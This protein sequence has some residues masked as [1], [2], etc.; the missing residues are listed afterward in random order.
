MSTEWRS[1]YTVLSLEIDENWYAPEMGTF[2]LH[3]NDLY[4]LYLGLEEI[5]AEE[6][7]RDYLRHIK[8][9][10]EQQLNLTKGLVYISHKAERFNHLR[11]V[12]IQYASPGNQDLAGIGVII[13]HIKDFILRLIELHVS[14]EERRLKNERLEIENLSERIKIAKE[15]GFT[16]KEI[17]NALGWAKKRQ[18]TISDLIEDGKILSVTERRLENHEQIEQGKFGGP[19]T[20]LLKRF[21]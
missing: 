19:F 5:Y 9:Q 18:K 16:D 7:A 4:R 1:I 21:K 20:K 17:R 12:R 14:K 6:R 3:L 10:G 2:L 8:E 13:G 11:V 15:V